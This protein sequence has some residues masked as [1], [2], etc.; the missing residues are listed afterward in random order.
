MHN[1][2]FAIR[3]QPRLPLPAIPEGLQQAASFGLWQY[4]GNTFELR[5]SSTAAE[6]LAVEEGCYRDVHRCFVNAAAEERD[7]LVAAF[8]Q[9]LRSGSVLDCNFRVSS[10]TR[11]LRW[12][13]LSAIPQL[14]SQSGAAS[15]MVADI[16]P[17]K[18]AEMR[19][20]FIFKFME[21]LVGAHTVDEVIAKVLPV[22]CESLGWDW[23]AYW[24]TA[25]DQPDVLRCRQHWRSP[26]INLAAFSQASA[27]TPIPTGLGLIGKVWSSA[28]ATWIEDMAS[29]TSFLRQ[30]AAQAS[31]LRSGYAFPVGYQ[32][33][34]GGQRRL[35]VLEFFS[36]LPRQPTAQLPYVA[37][38]VGGLIGQTVQRLVH[39]A[40]IRHM[41]QTDS[42]T[43]LANRAHFYQ[44]IDAECSNAMADKSSFGL[45]YIDLD[46][47]KPINDA[48]GHEAG[49]AVLK[50]FATRV[51]GLL[52]HGCFAGRLGGDEFC[53]LLKAKDFAAAVAQ[54][55]EAILCAARTPV[56]FNDCPLVIS[57]S[58]GISVF[59]EDGTTAAELLRNADVAMYRSK[60]S[61]R[62]LVSFSAN[63]P[64]ANSEARQSFLMKRMTIEG[65]LHKALERSEFFLDYQ[66][67]GDPAAGRIV[68]VEALIR[69]RRCNGE[70]VRPDEFIPVA[71]EA[72]L[73]S[74]ID[75]WV[76]RRAC[77]DLAAMHRAGLTD[78]RVSVNMAAPEF[79]R[80]TLPADLLA[81]T[82]AAGIEPEHLCLEL[83][84]R[85]MMTQADT[86]IPVMHALR[87]QGFRISLD[88]FGTGYS[89][90]ARLKILPITSVKIDRSFIRGLPGDMHD[91]AIVRAMLELASDM[92]LAIVAEGVET[93]EQMEALAELGDPLI[94][95]YLLGKPA[96]PEQIVSAYS[97]RAWQPQVSAIA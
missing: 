79:M 64:G 4:D 13:R 73:I 92:R 52:P 93:L 34:D 27:R 91:R 65:A 76:V 67:I 87:R 17:H 86:I 18:L 70:I 5:L 89:S 23:G 83:T 49:N 41:A 55:S 63:V 77:A 74:H 8:E 61:G 37:T 72:G 1:R 7:T 56:P 24:S 57:A 21:L 85:M 11:G 39:E 45:L 46:Q 19:E 62:N 48:F 95:G 33:A 35:G 50:E 31:A 94:Q 78:L 2:R 47:F 30:K 90:L 96:S 3:H 10:R 42:L 14:S 59:P 44:I 54:V 51:L 43:G 68:A 80:Q 97:R 81:V 53:V 40:S 82:R 12:L 25:P 88:D 60:K 38:A 32:A 9:H 29:D 84:E 58:I 36:R 20:R 6:L 69:W 26:A 22:V 15:G 28:Q 75:E 71:E 16:T 66:P